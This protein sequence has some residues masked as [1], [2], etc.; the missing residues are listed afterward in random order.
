MQHARVRWGNFTVVARRVARETAALGHASL[1]DGLPR[2]AAQRTLAHARS[3]E[4]PQWGLGQVA[5]EDRCGIS[6]VSSCLAH[7]FNAGNV[8]S[9]PCVIQGRRK[10]ANLFIEGR[11]GAPLSQ[12]SS[13]INRDPLLTSRHKRKSIEKAKRCHYN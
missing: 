2:Q 13:P 4:R 10:R 9:T 11:G 5:P 3:C 8:G 6:T 12:V 1:R 7:D